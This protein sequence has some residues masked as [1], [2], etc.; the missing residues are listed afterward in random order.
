MLKLQCVVRTLLPIIL[1]LA[2]ALAQNRRLE[3]EWKGTLDTSGPKLRLLLK[4]TK[5]ADGK[6]AA[7]IDS[8]DQGASI[9]VAEIAHMSDD[10]KLT[11]KTIAASYEGKMNAAGTESRASGTRAAPACPSRFSVRPSR[12]GTTR[13]SG[14]ASPPRSPVSR[15][16]GPFC[17]SST[18][19]GWA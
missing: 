16:R 1:V 7:T 3:G 8:L 6:L 12:R 18:K 5:G 13:N 10:V 11:L 2:P 15:T 17:C 9:P 14:M 19:N 4:V